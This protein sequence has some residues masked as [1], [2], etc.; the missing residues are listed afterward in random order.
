MKALRE[1]TFFPNFVSELLMEFPNLEA[2]QSY[3]ANQKI[4]DEVSAPPPP[5]SLRI[6]SHDFHLALPFLSAL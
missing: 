5:P 2:L 3:L 4:P 6:R 1:L